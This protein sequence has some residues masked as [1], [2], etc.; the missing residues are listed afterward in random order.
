LSLLDWHTRGRGEDACC[1]NT[2]RDRFGFVERQF[3]GGGTADPTADQLFA[4]Q[5]RVPQLGPWTHLINGRLSTGPQFPDAPIFGRLYSYYGV[6]SRSRPSQYDA[7]PW[8]GCGALEKVGPVTSVGRLAVTQL[9]L[10]A[11]PV[12]TSFTNLFT[13]SG[14]NSSRYS[15]FRGVPHG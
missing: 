11:Y 4:S 9:D 15:L 2:L 12:E 14:R 5:E 13:G 3:P 7:D 1:W 8:V 6:S 10:T